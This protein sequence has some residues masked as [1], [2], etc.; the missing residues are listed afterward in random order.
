MGRIST[1][2]LYRLI[3]MGIILLCLTIFFLDL[4]AIIRGSYRFPMFKRFFLFFLILPFLELFE[5]FSFFISHSRKY[6][7]VSASPPNNGIKTTVSL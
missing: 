2:L 6:T 5:F 3:R 4:Q 7:K 1:L